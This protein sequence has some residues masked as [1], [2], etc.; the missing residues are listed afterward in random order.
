MNPEL[1]K[2]IIIGVI[3][4]LISSWLFWLLLNYILAPSISTDKKIQH[5]KFKK[6]IRI[7]N[8]NKLFDAYEI[9]CY[10]EY[11]YH[12]ENK[13]TQKLYR[14]SLTLPILKHS[15]GEHHI[16]LNGSVDTE[17]VFDDPDAILNMTITYQNKLGIKKTIP[18]HNLTNSDET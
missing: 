3:S 17:K 14:T 7:Y 12:D 9:V 16:H 11:I 2:A 6:Y 1:Q 8:E 18:L 4:G 15:G 10:I 13:N 5:G